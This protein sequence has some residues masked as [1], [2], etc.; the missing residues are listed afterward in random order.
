MFKELERKSKYIETLQKQLA[1]GRAKE[2]AQISGLQADIDKT[3]ADVE[4][5][6]EAHKVTKKHVKLGESFFS[7][8]DRPYRKYVNAYVTTASAVAEAVLNNIF[9]DGSKKYKHR[10]KSTNQRSRGCQ[11]WGW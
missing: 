4:R 6:N 1:N 5:A 2:Q 3:E 10:T 8:V 7:Q 11:E 9:G